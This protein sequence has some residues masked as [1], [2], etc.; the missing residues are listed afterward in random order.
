M[1]PDADSVTARNVLVLN[2]QTVPQ[3]DQETKY[4]FRH[5]SSDIAHAAQRYFDEVKG[6]EKYKNRVGEVLDS[7]LTNLRYDS[8]AVKELPDGRYALVLDW[9][10][11]YGCFEG[12]RREM[13]RWICFSKAAQGR[14]EVILR[15]WV[16]WS[17]REGYFDDEHYREFMM[18]LGVRAK[19][20]RFTKRRSLKK[21]KLPSVAGNLIAFPLRQAQEKGER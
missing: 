7:F 1:P 16:R 4:D 8:S 15:K 18:G 9:E 12:F 19:D 20:L 13:R 11:Y 2:A 17:Y 3:V 14:Y 6:N 10:V 5:H 21:T